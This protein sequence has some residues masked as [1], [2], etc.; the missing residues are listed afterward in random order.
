ML[1]TT[2]PLQHFVWRI[3]DNSG[4]GC[5]TI[6]TSWTLHNHSRNF[7]KTPV[8]HKDGIDYDVLNCS[9]NNCG[10]N[11]INQ[12]YSWFLPDELKKLNDRG[13]I[14]SVY[15]VPEDKLWVGKKQVVFS[16]KDLKPKYNFRLDSLLNYGLT[17]N[18]FQHLKAED[19]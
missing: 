16:R 13:F 7:N 19:I 12:L 2:A 4:R 11:S 14:C 10:F 17:K 5:Y 8:P 15:V 1:N 6:G 18:K 9:D 3:E